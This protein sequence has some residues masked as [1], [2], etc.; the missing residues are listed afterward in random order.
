MRN[1]PDGMRE[2]DIPGYWLTECRNCEDYWME[3]G[4][5]TAH[6]TD[7]DCPY[8]EGTGMVDTREQETSW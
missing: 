4:Q 2:S 7:P 5:D 3:H 1:Y 6:Q 8:C